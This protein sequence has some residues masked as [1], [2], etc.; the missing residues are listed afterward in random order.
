MTELLD[1]RLFQLAIFITVL[2]WLTAMLAMAGNKP[3][4]IGA[5]I[6]N[7]F[8][9]L[10]RLFAVW[11]AKWIHARDRDVA[12]WNA[13]AKHEEHA[14]ERARYERIASLEDRSDD[15]WL[16]LAFLIKR[17]RWRGDDP[18]AAPADGNGSFRF[19]GYKSAPRARWLGSFLTC[20]RIS[21]VSAVTTRWSRFQSDWNS[22]WRWLRLTLRRDKSSLHF[23]E[24]AQ[25]QSHLVGTPLSPNRLFGG[26]LALVAA[27][28]AFGWFV[29]LPDEKIAAL[30]PCDEIGETDPRA[31]C[32][33]LHLAENENSILRD[34]IRAANR[35][36]ETAESIARDSADASRA[37]ATTHARMSRE[38]AV[39]LER[40]LKI[41]ADAA[42]EARRIAT[43]AGSPRT[44]Q[45][46]IAPIGGDEPFDGD[47]WM[48]DRGTGAAPAAGTNPDAGADR[49]S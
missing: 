38:S 34:Q 36:A 41:Q 30:A 35:R 46:E 13:Q 31:S 8:S 3:I 7:M 12:Y 37:A 33:Q 19:A 23:G 32:K 2:I 15:E 28:G 24:I 43:D 21:I 5:C 42:A 16:E 10:H 25:V 22:F 40:R 44:S 20:L 6:S 29:R 26:L 48:R 14:H 4:S 9:S 49:P 11:S 47:R 17:L 18:L 1:S 39:R 45:G 27:W